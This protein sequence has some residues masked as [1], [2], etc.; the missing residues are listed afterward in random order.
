[1]AA[2][3]VQ[4]VEGG[5]LTHVTSLALTVA[6]PVAGN[7]LIAWTNS[8][9]TQTV[10]TDNGS[11]TGWT[12]GPSVVNNNAA[13]LWWR[14]A[15]AT[16]ASSMTTVTHH[17]TATESIHCGFAEFSGVAASPGDVNNTSTTTG[18]AHTLAASITTT[19]TS[20]DLVFTIAATSDER[21]GIP[22]GPSWTNSY[23][24]VVP[25]PTST[26]GTTV[27]DD[28]TW[29]AWLNQGTSGA[30]ST[31]GSWTNAPGNVQ[32]LIIGFKLAAAAAAG[33]PDVTMAPRG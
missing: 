22:S 26:G 29:I 25:S 17:L 14:I 23:T 11:N 27:D 24:N 3:L 15:T 8:G 10:A 32:A 6:K 19:G 28:A 13:Y 21:A 9:S 31:V 18:V 12:L 4:H 20:G 7:L 2:S 1:M 30:T 5:S 16:D 33:I